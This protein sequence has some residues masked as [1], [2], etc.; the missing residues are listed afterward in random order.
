ME[1]LS[2]TFSGRRIGRGGSAVA[3]WEPSSD[4]PWF[5]FWAYVK[6]YVYL[7]KSRDLKHLKASR[8]R[9]ICYGVY[10]RKSVGHMQGHEQLSLCVTIWALRHEVDVLIHVIFTSALVGGKSSASRPRPLYFRKSPRYPLDM[11][12]FGLRTGLDDTERRKF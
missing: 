2:A 9:E 3:T 7:N 1:I 12:L 5:F 10:G 8:H 4:T 6:N 11:R